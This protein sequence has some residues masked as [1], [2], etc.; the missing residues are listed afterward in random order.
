MSVLFPTVLILLLLLNVSSLTFSQNVRTNKQHSLCQIQAQ[1]LADHCT[2]YEKTT[3]TDEDKKAI[4]NKINSRRNKVASGN[5]SSFPSS[6]NMMKLEWSDALET[7]AQRWADQCVLQNSSDI[8]DP[9]RDLENVLVGQNIA[10][11]HGDAPGLWPVSLVDVW[12]MELLHTNAS[13]ISRY[14]PSSETG[15]SHYDYFTQLVWAESSHVGC[16]S[17]KYKQIIN[18]KNKIMNKT[19]NRLVCNFSPSGNLLYKTVYN[20]GPACSR[21]LYDSV[22][23]TKYEALCSTP[24][25]K[26]TENVSKNMTDIAQ[27]FNK[28]NTHR[29]NLSD[30]TKINRTT[31]DL[32]EDYDYFT[33]YNYFSRFLETPKLTTTLNVDNSSSCKVLVAVDNLLELIKKKLGKD[34]IFK[35][36]ILSG[37]TQVSDIPNTYTDMSV[38]ALVNQLY[39][40]KEVATTVKPTESDNINSTLLIDLVEAVIFRNGDKISTTEGRLEIIQPES[41]MSPVKIRA[42]LPEVKL[43]NDFSGHYFFPE[44]E[45]EEISS[46][47]TQIYDDISEL[48]ISDIA[49]EIE[50][51]KRQKSTKDFLE[52]IIEFESAP[53]NFVIRN[54][55]QIYFENGK[56]NRK[57]HHNKNDVPLRKLR[58]TKELDLINNR[59]YFVIR[60]NILLEK[61]AQDLKILKLN[62]RF[63]C[64]GSVCLKKSFEL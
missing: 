42:E 46:E 51:L 22:C 16:G 44:D 1:I 15:L 55:R 23:D 27:K 40:T 59:D 56:N 29:Q 11:V 57:I 7:S 31:T 8:L 50:D 24:N 41:H 4:L 20:V 34:P 14:I 6:E 43:N 18:D 62:E 19:I 37:S 3:N 17:V 5:I 64:S 38:A 13:I 12:Y 49:L 33:P 36:L 10:T 2:G 32:T 53:E 26:E 30:Y 48:P 58:N 63:H 61:I 54:K 47:T 39:S 9:C 60:Y 21:C 45:S 52:D 35:E 28:A 25:Q